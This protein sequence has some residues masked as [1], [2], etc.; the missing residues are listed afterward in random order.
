MSEATKYSV[1]IKNGT[2]HLAESDGGTLV[3]VDDYAALQQKQEETEALMY[4]MRHDMRES[5]ENMEA[6]LAENA[7]IK[8]GIADITFM[9]DDDFFASTQEAQRVMGNLVN[10]KTPATDTILNEVR[11]EGAQLCIDA[12]VTSGSDDFID[13]PNICAD[14][15]RQ[16]RASSAE[17]ATND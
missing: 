17:G 7:E 14:V 2:Y 1:V 16:L 3:L 5:R 8:S 4:A 10:I 13:A 12:I 11:A 15:V 9:R 6:M